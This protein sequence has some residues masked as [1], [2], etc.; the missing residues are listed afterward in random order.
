M[1]YLSHYTEIITTKLLKSNQAFYAFGQSQF[2]QKKVKGTQYVSVGQGLVVPKQ[3]M[4]I[5]ISGMMLVNKQAIALDL[6]ENGKDAII[7]RELANYECQISC[8]PSDAV[9]ALVDYGITEQEVQEGYK[10]FFA[11]CIENDWF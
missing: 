6:A 2:D 11:E 9:G 10:V 1:Q 7:Q 4:E 8:D 3:N 5:V